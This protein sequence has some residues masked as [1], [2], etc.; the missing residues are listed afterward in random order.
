MTFYHFSIFLFSFLFFLLNILN[1]LL[2]PLSLS[3]TP[4]RPLKG[5]QK[6]PKGFPKKNDSQDPQKTPERPRRIPEKQHS[7]KDPEGFQKDPRKTPIPVASS[8]FGADASASPAGRVP[9]LAC[10]H[11]APLRLP[12]R[13][14]C[15]YPSR[16]SPTRTP[17]ATP[18]PPPP[19]RLLFSFLSFSTYSVSSVSVGPRLLWALF[20]SHLF[21]F[22]PFL[23][24]SFSPP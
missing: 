21:L 1:I 20:S 23:L 10:H 22:F 16:G 19:P 8:A 11:P 9:R 6:T 18:P 24:P 13:C 4:E 17:P 2:N 5:P 3:K 7:Q 12:T 14:T 15:Q